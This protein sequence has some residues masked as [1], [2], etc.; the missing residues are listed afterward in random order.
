[1][2]YINNQSVINIFEDFMVLTSH[3]MPRW[4]FLI[5]SLTV[6]V[7]CS[8]APPEQEPI[9][10]VKVLTVGA[11]A[12]SFDLE[13]SGEVRARIESTLGFRVGGKLIARQAELG[14]RVKAGQL[15]AQIDPQDYRVAADAAAA[16]LIAAQS[17]RDVAAADL[18]RYQNL[19]DQGFISAAELERRQA[20][21]KAA[22]AQWRQAQAQNTVQGNQS[23]YTHLLADGAGVITS[24]DASAGQVMA[25]GQSVVRLALD[26]PR[27][28]VFAVSEDKLS[29]LKAGVVVDVRQWADGKTFEAKVRDVSASADAITRTFIVKASLP[30]EA[31]PV[32]GSTVTV[33]L[34]AANLKGETPRIKLPTS[35][36][37]TEA[38]ATSV[39]VLDPA[40]MT[41]KA[42]AIQ[43]ST[44]DGNEAVVDS[45]LQNG[46]QVVISGV[47]VLTAG[48]KV[49]IFGAAK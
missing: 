32:L 10:A 49:S 48:Q 15:L 23:N 41:V 37:R 28:V 20:S 35:A 33:S 43:V 40:T 16:Q 39:W 7:G 6:L 24:V 14:Q 29:S 27:D 26:G 13:F 19:F 18:K 46:D 36:L 30:K 4:L 1:M 2:G 45:G 44:A 47:H 22:H 9:R 42:Q 38:G 3:T 25:A 31:D 12:T 17:N 34:S 21:D 8:K 11:S 5:I